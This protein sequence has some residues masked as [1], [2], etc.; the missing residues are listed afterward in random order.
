MARKDNDTAK[1]VKKL[2]KSKY[3]GVFLIIVIILV[4][5]FVLYCSFNPEFY[6]SIFGPKGG[7][8]LRTKEDVINYY[9]TFY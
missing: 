2:A 3:F 7:E 1:V 8:P 9:D 4:A 6:N 5:A